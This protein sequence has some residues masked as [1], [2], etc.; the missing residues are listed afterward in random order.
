[1]ADDGGRKNHE[2][3]RGREATANKSRPLRGQKGFLPNG[4]LVGPRTG[5]WLKRLTHWEVEGCGHRT[6]NLH[7]RNML[8]PEN[9]GKGRGLIVNP[10]GAS[11]SAVQREE[12]RWK[13]LER[14]EG[15]ARNCLNL[16]LEKGESGWGTFLGGGGKERK[17]TR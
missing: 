13:A 12:C 9:K 6:R 16:R 17:R 3:I 2:K 7:I 14:R 4:R 15:R 10:Q 8:K 1:M 11:T 5:K